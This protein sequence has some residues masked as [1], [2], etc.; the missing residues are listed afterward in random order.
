MNLQSTEYTGNKGYCED[1]TEGKFS[2]PVVHAVRADAGSRELL[3]ES[4]VTESLQ[5]SSD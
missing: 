4:V 2:F 5:Q 3:S 1:L